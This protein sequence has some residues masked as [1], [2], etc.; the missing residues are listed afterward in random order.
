MKTGIWDCIVD[1]TMMEGCGANLVFDFHRVVRGNLLTFQRIQ[2]PP[3]FSTFM[4]PCRSTP[5][6][7]EG[8]K[9]IMLGTFERSANVLKQHRGV[10]LKHKGKLEVDIRAPE[11]RKSVH[12]PGR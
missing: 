6:C 8:M 3:S 1:A 5:P 12:R 11:G 9:D 2:G 7:M 10:N 4:V